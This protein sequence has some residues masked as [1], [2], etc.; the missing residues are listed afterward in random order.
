MHERPRMPAITPDTTPEEAMKIWEQ[1]LMGAEM[2][3]D[4]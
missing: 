4:G 2:K 3:D 1:V